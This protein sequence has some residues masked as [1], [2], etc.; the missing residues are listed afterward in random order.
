MQKTQNDIMKIDIPLPCPDCGGKMYS[1][2]YD[3]TLRILKNRTWHVCKECR[4]TR[5]VEEF[6]KTLCCA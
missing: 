2:G 4:F 6:K 3:A 5:N 1:V